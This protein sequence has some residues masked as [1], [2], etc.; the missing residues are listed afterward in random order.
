MTKTWPSKSTS[1]FFTDF[2][3]LFIRIK[4]IEKEILQKESDATTH[5]KSTATSAEKNAR[6]GP[7]VYVFFTH[8]NRFKPTA[9]EIQLTEELTDSLLKLKV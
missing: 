7:F 2:I 3:H 1:I 8:G 5:E 9:L 4:E 6:L